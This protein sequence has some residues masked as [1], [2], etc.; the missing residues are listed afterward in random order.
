MFDNPEKV[1]Y[2]KEINEK[3]VAAT[4]DAAL[5][6]INITLNKIKVILNFWAIKNWIK[7]KS[8]AFSKDQVLI[9][10]MQP[11]ETFREKMKLRH[12][13]AKFIVGFLYNR[14][15]ENTGT[16]KEEAFVE[17]SVLELKD[18]FERSIEAFGR[19]I[20][21]E[22]VEDSLFYL[23]RIEALKIEGGFL[24]VYNRLT[25]ERLEKTTR[26]ATNSK[27]TRDSCGSMKTRFSKF[28]SS[29]NMPKR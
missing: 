22:E 12:E 25:I 27:I 5:K 28:I 6:E 18:A 20:S 10:W 17:F 8:P 21:L 26:N 9:T 7:R 24:V 19:K 15:T 1:F 11:K 29:G 2:L 13:L 23:S 3:A 14:S 16:D 4:H